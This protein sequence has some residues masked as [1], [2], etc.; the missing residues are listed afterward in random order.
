VS[1][2]DDGGW[3]HRLQRVE[4]LI[5]EMEEGPESPVRERARDIVRAV[6]DLHADA[7]KKMMDVVAADGSTAVLVDAFARDP[8]IAGMLLLHSLHP[9]DFESR[10]RG[11]L[12]ALTPD[13]RKHR[14]RVAAVAISDGVVRV[15]LERAP[16]HGGRAA[17]ALRAQVEDAIVAVAPDAATIDIEV[18]EEFLAFVPL[19]H[20]RLRRAPSEMRP[21]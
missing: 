17:P 6:L 15:R 14:V 18:S 7:L 10:V 8:Q 3:E 12:D 13:L 2:R 19:E 11:A 4:Q 9:L 16:G 5:R 21:R 1:A 20:V